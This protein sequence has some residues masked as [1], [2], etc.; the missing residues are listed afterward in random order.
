VVDLVETSQQSLQQANPGNINDVRKQP[1]PLIG[2]SEKMKIQSLELK[3]FLRNNLYQHYRVHRMTRKADRI[4]QDLFDGF[5]NDIKLLPPE[6]Q[7]NVKEHETNS[8]D[9]GKAR[10][11]SDYIAGMTDRYAIM[12]H[13]R[14]FDPSELT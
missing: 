1:T 6:H 12:E 13:K 14:I 8:G 9:P 10:A 4:I 7:Q 11:V 3:R 2:F 5:M